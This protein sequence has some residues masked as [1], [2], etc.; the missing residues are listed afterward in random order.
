[1]RSFV[2]AMALAFFALP[3]Y[4]QNTVSIEDGAIV[5]HGNFNGLAGIEATS[6]GGHL[7]VER[8][9]GLGF[10]LESKSPFSLGDGRV[11]QNTPNAVILGVLGVDKRIDVEG[12]AKTSILYSE[13]RDIA[14]FDL[15]VSVGV[16]DSPPILLRC[17]TCPEPS[18]SGMLLLGLVGL[19]CCRTHRVSSGDGHVLVPGTQRDFFRSDGTG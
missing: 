18:S 12:P 9:Y 5:L 2:A 13:S 4:A 11:V 7:S 8:L 1:M 15:S 16:G 6:E 10:F 19:A 14:S 17:P 3:A